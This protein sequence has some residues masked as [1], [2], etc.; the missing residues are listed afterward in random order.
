[1]PEPNEP[2]RNRLLDA[3]SPAARIRLFPHLEFVAMPADQPLHDSGAVPQEVYF[4]IDCIISLLYVTERGA[5]AEIAAVGSE[6]LLG[7]SLFMGG[8][9]TPGRAVVHSAGH[10]FRLAGTRLKHE[11]HSDRETQLLLLNYTQALL[12]QMA[13]TAVCN[14]HHSVD[15]QLCRWL[16]LSFD[17]LVAEELLTTEERVAAMLGAHRMAVSE[18]AGRLQRLGA[19]RYDGGSILVHDRS[20]LE[21]LCCECYAVLRNATNRLLPRPSG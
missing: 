21:R 1:M 13:Q 14:R 12:T 3:L 2:S 6:G 18:A 17:R 7:T 9:T 15:Q 10:A 5:S 11:F 8:A 4:P 20:G 16:L 19:I